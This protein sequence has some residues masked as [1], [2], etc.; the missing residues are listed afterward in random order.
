[1]NVTKFCDCHIHIENKKAN[2][3]RAN[4]QASQ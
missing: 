1:L 3:K 4:L 2:A